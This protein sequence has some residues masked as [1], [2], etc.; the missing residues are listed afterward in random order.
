MNDFHLKKD[1]SEWPLHP[2]FGKFT[3][4]QYGKMNYKH[5]D[6]HLT[7]FGV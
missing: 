2:V 7:Q 4:E 3:K 5:L 1:Q 6:H